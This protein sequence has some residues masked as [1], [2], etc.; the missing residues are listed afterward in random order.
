MGLQTT[1]VILND[2]AS[3]IKNNPDVGEV[4][5]Q[6]IASGKTGESIISGIKFIEMHHCD[7]NVLVQVGQGGGHVFGNI[8]GKHCFDLAKEAAVIMEPHDHPLAYQL[9]KATTPETL[10]PI[11]KRCIRKVGR[12]TRFDQNKVSTKEMNKLVD[13]YIACLESTLELA[14]YMKEE[15]K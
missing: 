2:Y 3:N 4:I 14:Y 9:G 13:L 8:G 5:Y 1:I 12:K 6:M 11:A 7:N 15:K 10:L